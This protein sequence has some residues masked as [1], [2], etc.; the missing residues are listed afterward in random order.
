MKRRWSSARFDETPEDPQASLVNL[1]DIMLVFICGLIVALVSAQ[2]AFDKSSS[3]LE[4]GE[5]VVEPG[6]ELAEMPEGLRG[7]AAGAGLE[8]VGQVYRD[9]QT[10]KLILVGQ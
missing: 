2:P 6:R 9:P 1:V 3:R 7:Q 4:G 10:G 5:Q 8:P